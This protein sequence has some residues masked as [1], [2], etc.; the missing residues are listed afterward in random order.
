MGLEEHGLI[1]RFDG[2]GDGGVEALEVADGDDAA[3]VAGD[4]DDAIG[5]V[6]GGDEGLFDEDVDAGAEET[7]GD[8]CVVDGGH[9]DGGG[10]E[11]E[12]GGEEIVD[13]GEG[14]DV[15]GGVGGAAR[16]VGLDECDELDE[17][18]VCGGELAV[19]AQVVATEGA[20]ADDGDAKRWHGGLLRGRRCGGFHGG[21][22]AC[23][24]SEDVVDLIFG[25]DGR[26]DAEAGR[27]GGLGTEIGVR[28]DE[29]EQVEG[30]VLGAACVGVGADVHRAMVAGVPDEVQTPWM[31]VLVA[32]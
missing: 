13:C 23:V 5:L 21:A 12:A 2:G 18:G 27:G 28:G 17:L 15:V 14:M 20:G 9:A 16:G 7:F 32:W 29:L 26:R 30:D 4:V 22:A 24:E 19:D 31:G 1:E 8:G 25:L 3:V 10:V 6:E 11:G